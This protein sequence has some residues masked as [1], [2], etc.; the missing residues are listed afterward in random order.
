MQLISD[1]RLERYVLGL[2]WGE[3]PDAVRE[4]A[5]ACALDLVGALS[6]GSL[7]RQF[8]VG[9]TL[10]RSIFASGDV[11]ILGSDERFSLVGATVAMGHAANSFDIDDGHSLIKRHPGA[12]FISGLM[13]AALER[14]VTY[15]EF[16][17]TLVAG[18]DVAVRAGL[19]MQ[20][21]YVFLHSTGCYGAVAT[22]ACMGRL[23]GLDAA[24]LNTALA[25]ADFHAPL[26][27]VMR[28]VEIPSMSKDGVPFGALVG[29]MAVQEAVAGE[30]GR[31]HTLE[32]A[33]EARLLDDL[34]ESFEIMNLYFKP[35]TCCRWAHQPIRA[36]LALMDERGLAPSDVAHVTVHTFDAAAH[37]SKAVPRETDE[38]QYNITWPVAAAIAHEDL[39]YAEV[40]DEALSDP[41]TLDI[42]GRLDFVVDPK[43]EAQFP[44]RRRAWVEVVTTSGATLRSPICE[45][46][47]E[48]SDD[49]GPAWVAKKFRRVTAPALGS[50]DQERI[51][52][53]L[54]SGDVTTPICEIIDT[55][56]G[57]LSARRISTEKEAL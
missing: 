48:A 15:G 46:E 28:S 54:L 37:L 45:A 51:V 9:L 35:Y 25:I 31:V 7:G 40:R 57:A 30:S 41:A 49:I 21:S 6:L 4:R 12:S 27:P 11:P 5:R 56:N 33:E 23:M 42:M 3:L 16:L 38:A 34:E 32:L 18:Y 24:Q 19:A 53:T 2:T 1:L 52:T 17:T 55:V 36:A 43:L 47:G 44:A 26:T 10:A 29:A 13:A 20:E 14:N 50:D 8:S 39:G 22:A